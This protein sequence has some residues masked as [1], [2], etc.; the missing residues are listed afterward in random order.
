MDKMLSQ[1]GRAAWA[2]DVVRSRPG[3]SSSVPSG[4][5]TC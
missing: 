1:V 3:V 4:G 5:A 2:P